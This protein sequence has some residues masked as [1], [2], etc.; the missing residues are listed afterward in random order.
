MCGKV[1]PV[2]QEKPNLCTKCETALTPL[3]VR[4]CPSC[5]KPLDAGYDKPFCVFCTKKAAGID[6]VISPFAY[7][8]EVRQSILKFKFGGKAFYAESYAAILYN[9]LKQ[10]GKENAFDAIVPVPISKNRRKMRGYSQALC[11]AKALSGLC[12]TPALD[13]LC[14]TKETPPQSTLSKTARA[15]NLNGAI[16][17]KPNCGALP[18]RIL[19]IDDV[20]TTGTTVRTCAKILRQGG[21]KQIAA[22]TVAMHL[23]DPTE[24]D[25]SDYE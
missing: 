21:A 23:P 12:Q 9:R 18:E 17:L 20:Y 19:L 5:H 10:Y 24:I 15:T 25:L 4:V 6:Y 16:A 22:A 1:L 11:I 14:K 3:P 13:I 7:T 2:F 8:K